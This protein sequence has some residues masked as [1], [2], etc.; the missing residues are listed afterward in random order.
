NASFSPDGSR[1]VTASE[2]QT[3]RVWD[4][5]SGQ[6]IAELGGHSATVLNASFSPV[7]GSRIVTASEDQTARVWDATSGQQIAELGGHSA[8]VLNASFSPDGSRIV[9]ASE[10]NSARVWEFYPFRD[11]LVLGCNHLN[12]YLIANPEK[13]SDLPAC[14]TAERTLAAAD[15]LIAQ[16]DALAQ[17][18]EIEQAIKKYQAALDW[19]QIVNP[20]RRARLQSTP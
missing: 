2:D 3:A 18:G 14:Q 7:D 1:I 19:G 13:L 9:T 20:E 17:S 16:G 5:A 8:T 10:D 6:Q 11:L 4:A 15:T 12:N